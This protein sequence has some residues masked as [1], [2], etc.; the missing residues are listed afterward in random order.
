M[1][2]PKVPARAASR[3]LRAGATRGSQPVAESALM[4]GAALLMVGLETRIE[5]LEAE[6]KQLRGQLVHQ[7]PSATSA[8]AFELSSGSAAHRLGVSKAALRRWSEQGWIGFQRTP[9][10]HRRYSSTQIADLVARQR[11]PVTRQ[12]RDPRG[13]QGDEASHNPKEAS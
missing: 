10:G 4:H 9:G 6:V 2:S 11:S 8:A 3:E 7:P 12:E 13:Q 1:D 5:Q